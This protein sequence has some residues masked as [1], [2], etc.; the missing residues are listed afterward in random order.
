MAEE[1]KTVEE[2]ELDSAVTSDSEGSKA[3]AAKKTDKPV[4]KKAKKPGFFARLAKWFRDLRSEAKKVIWPTKKQVTNN[5][6][7]VVVMVI[8][9]AVFVAALDITFGFVRDFLASLTSLI[10]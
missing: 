4:A 7:V 3:P 1:N 10:G 9:V 6:V 5:T 2:Q 8:V